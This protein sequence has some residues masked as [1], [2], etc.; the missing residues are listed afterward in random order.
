MRPGPTLEHLA[1]PRTAGAGLDVFA[2]E[3]TTAQLVWSQLGPG[4][5]EVTA[6][7]FRTVVD[8]P[9]GAGAVEIRGLAPGATQGV[10]VRAPTGEVHRRRVRTLPAPPGDELFRFATVNDLHLGR[11]EH[12][13]R[14]HLPHGDR[15]A[16]N[17]PFTA[18]V[19]AIAEALDWG[20]Q[21][22]VA[23][24]DICDESH[25]WTWEQA[26]KLLADVPVPVALLPGNHDTGRLRSLDPVA[27]AT[28]HGLTL[29]RGIDHVDVPGL[30]VVLVDS[31]RDGIGWG[32]VA[33]HADAAASLARDA[34][35]G[36][37]VATH[38]QAQRFP[39]PTYWP[40][41][42]P[43][44][45]AGRFARAVVSANPR[46]M[47]SSGHTHRCRVRGVAGLTWSEVAATNHFPAV[48]AGYRV[49]EGGLMQVVRRTATPGTLAW[50]EHTR[51]ALRGIWALW[52]TGT[53]SDRC[54]TLRW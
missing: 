15:E 39:F 44:P 43:G 23:K 20:A 38:H 28:R 24:G 33:R 32:Q 5:V 30:R 54:F 9:G 47:A 2:V 51:D 52:A 17:H 45:E 49:F 53:L 40:H 7:R 21:L 19:D 34:E 6:G 12:G 41:G 27:G 26:A 31:A 50:S 35:G 3:D 22:L 8:H 10:V 36:V 37:F 29:T 25:D 16:A 1:R 14:G 48:W 18:A 4:A 11:G 13:L 46:A 42:I